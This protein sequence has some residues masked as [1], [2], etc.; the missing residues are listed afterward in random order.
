MPLLD[1]FHAPLHPVHH[2]ESF[3]SNWAT[4]IADALSDRLPKEYI[5]EEHTHAGP[6]L[7]I[8]V[9]TLERQTADAKTNGGPV[10]AVAPAV[11]TPPAPAITLPSVI[12]ESFEVR[13]FSTAEGL[14][15]VAAIEFVSPSNKDRAA[16]RLAFASKVASYLYR[17]VSVIVIDIVT[18]RHANLHN[19]TMR[20]MEMDASAHF[21]ADV[22][23][24]AAAYR[25]VMRGEKAEIE[26]WP[27]RLTLGGALPTLP[28]RLVGDIFLPVDFETTY[29][30][31]CR[32]RRIS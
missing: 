12:P 26:V 6:N 16:E 28:L 10:T 17:G 31:A 19:E 25:P 32:R 2:W 20:L 18:S 30:E 21:P 8:D 5:V 15:L 29:Q 4:R 24:Y 27:E 3:H 13:V 7:E 14:T 11:Y 23:L 22:R 1:H 9:A